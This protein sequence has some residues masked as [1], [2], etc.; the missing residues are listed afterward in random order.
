MLWQNGRLVWGPREKVVHGWLLKKNKTKQK[1]NLL[2]KVFLE[3]IKIGIESWLY[4]F[5]DTNSNSLN[6][7]YLALMSL[8]KLLWQGSEINAYGRAL[9][10]I[11]RQCCSGTWIIL[12]N[13]LGLDFNY[14][15][16]EEKVLVRSHPR[17]AIKSKKD[18][19]YR[20][21][22]IKVPHLPLPAQ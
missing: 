7:S 20:V 6:L 15:R 10:Y 16:N 4:Y 3:L 18:N 13:S 14:L 11:G 8:T 12:L 2:R 5:C 19:G 21:G 9:G 17:D 1:K 22:W